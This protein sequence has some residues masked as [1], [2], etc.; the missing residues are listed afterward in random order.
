[1]SLPFTLPPRN[2]FSRS[3]IKSAV[4]A[5]GQS[6]QISIDFRIAVLMFFKSPRL[7]VVGQFENP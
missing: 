4:D 6:W 5:L 7:A 2:R 3:R 1:M